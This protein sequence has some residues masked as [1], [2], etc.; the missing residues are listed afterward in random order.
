MDMKKYQEMTNNTSIYAQLASLRLINHDFNKNNPLSGLIND[1]I[2]SVIHKNLNYMYYN[3]RYEV[4]GV[5]KMY[6]LFIHF[7]L[8][9]EIYEN[10]IQYFYKLELRSLI[11]PILRYYIDLLKE[12]FIKLNIPNIANIPDKNQ[13]NIL[14]TENYHLNINV[15]YREVPLT[16]DLFKIDLDMY[17]EDMLY[18]I[19]MH[20]PIFRHKCNRYS[21]KVYI[22]YN[23]I[24]EI[25]YYEYEN[26]KYFKEYVD[27]F[28]SKINNI[29]SLLCVM[30]FS[31]NVI[32]LENKYMKYT[33]ILNEMNNLIIFHHRIYVDL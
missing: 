16:I 13:D 9:T 30:N 6:L 32:S 29:L 27:I 21:R 17:D 10:A 12:D 4:L 19:I 24:Y 25:F 1:D 2:L 23:K 14:N 26:N 28:N 31:H 15:I 18:I 11:K 22:S 33:T 5:V 7:K 3:S 20:I 8:S